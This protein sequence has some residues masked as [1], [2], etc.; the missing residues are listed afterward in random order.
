MYDS[1]DDDPVGPRFVCALC[2]LEIDP[3]QM[4]LQMTFGQIRLGTKSKQHLFHP[5]ESPSGICEMVVHQECFEENT[6]LV[7][8][9]YF[10]SR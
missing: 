3:G 1:E 2:E 9:M 7:M 10:N 6:D 8:D 4:V 5:E